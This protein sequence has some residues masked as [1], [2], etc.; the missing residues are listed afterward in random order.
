MARFGELLKGGVDSG[1]VVEKDGVGGR[2]LLWWRSCVGSCV[3]DVGSG[4]EGYVL[5]GAPNKGIAV[6]DGDMGT[7]REWLMDG[8]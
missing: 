7:W 2:L 3:F 5:D 4:R 8:I 1:A 6:L